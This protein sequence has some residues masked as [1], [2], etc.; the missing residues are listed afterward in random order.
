MEFSLFLL[1]WGF[2]P[3]IAFNRLTRFQEKLSQYQP[4]MSE[5]HFSEFS[6][7]RE[8]EERVWESVERILVKARKCC[9]DDMAEPE[10]GQ[11]VIRPL[12][13]TALLYTPWE[14]AINAQNM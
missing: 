5:Y 12:L 6:R 7:T 3:R 8:Q 9:E 10:W 11:A 14:D 2:E 4:Y 1:K 13:E